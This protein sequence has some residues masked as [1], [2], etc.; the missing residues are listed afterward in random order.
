MRG[1]AYRWFARGIGL[2]L[3]VGLIVLLALGL[4]MAARVAVLVF[5]A[6]LLASALDPLVDRLRARLPVGRGVVVLLV[7]AVF[8]II[9]LLLAFLIVPGAIA[10]FGDLGQKL[11]PLLADARAWAATIEPRAL[12]QSLR[13][14]ITAVEQTVARPV[15]DEPDADDI[16]AIGLTVA[17]IAISVAAVLA[18]VYFWLTGRAR[19]QRFALAML[20][21]DRRAGTREAWNEVEFRLGAWVR[22]Q[23]ILM[24]SIGLMT[25]VAYAVIGLEGAVLLA[26]I[27]ALAEA[28]P[29]VGPALGAIPALVVAA[30]TGSIETVLL[31]AVVYAAIQTVESNVLVPIVMRNTVGV[32]PFMVVAGVLAGAAIA[33]VVGAV[34]AVP[35]VAAVIVVLSR[36]QAR[37][38]VVLLEP[39]GVEEPGPFER[40]EPPEVEAAGPNPVAGD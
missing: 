34:V 20:P 24:G 15:P 27:A 23:L 16:I 25:G 6:I 3:G 8:F 13:A 5:I 30:T 26:V 37:Q 36:I 38:S 17:D 35:L 28:I 14:V 2:A 40:S 18:M 10:Q 31:V 7:Y 32:P 1:E 12:S 33:G 4:G 29:L 39:A 19:L 22:A 9:V 21:E 11:A